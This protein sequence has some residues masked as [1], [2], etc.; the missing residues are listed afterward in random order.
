MTRRL[1]HQA[2]WIGNMETNTDNLFAGGTSNRLLL[3]LRSGL[4]LEVDYALELL[5]QYSHSA[6]AAS[7]PF[8]SLPG[9]P[10]AL[11]DLVKTSL[12]KDNETYRRRLEAA[13]VLR[14]LAFEGSQ[15]C[16]DT[17]RPCTFQIFEILYECLREEGQAE[18]T[19]YLLGLAE[20]FASSFTLLPSL[21][22]NRVTLDSPACQREIYP[23]LAELAQS[24]DRALVIGAYTLLGALALNEQNMPVFASRPQSPAMSVHMLSKTSPP[25]STTRLVQRAILLLHLNDSDLL[26]PIF[27]FMYQHTLIPANGALLLLRKDLRDLFRLFTSRIKQEATEETIEYEILNRTEATDSTSKLR[28]MA[29]RAALLST[30]PNL[31]AQAQTD[32][33]QTS[34]PTDARLD[35]TEVQ[36]ILYLPEPQRVK[37]WMHAVFESSTS[38]EITQVALWKAY[39]KQFDGFDTQMK[40]GQVPAMLSASDVI[41]TSSDAFAEA[42]PRVVEDPNQ[43][44]TKRFIISGIRI[45]YRP[46]PVEAISE[47]FNDAWRCKWRD[48]PN[49]ATCSNAEQLYEHLI[50]SH[51]STIS[52]DAPSTCSYGACRHSVRSLRDLT[53]HLRTHILPSAPSNALGPTSQ[54]HA[55]DA[56]DRNNSSFQ[57]KTMKAQL[58]DGGYAAGIGFVAS[59]VMRNCARAVATST[60]RYRQKNQ[61]T[62]SNDE[63]MQ[64]LSSGGD[65]SEEP[66]SRLR[67]VQKRHEGPSDDDD[68]ERARMAGFLSGTL[69]HQHSDIPSSSATL[70]KEVDLDRRHLEK[71]LIALLDVEKEIIA[72]AA[73]NESLATYLMETLECIEMAK[74]AV[75]AI[76]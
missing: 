66:S 65:V 20:I 18:L 44:Q 8:E 4:P 17:I 7:I 68:P 42:Q 64:G 59:L 9:L 29:L 14:N 31:A 49:S 22:V 41:K 16:L 51:I 62:Q 27:E 72:L 60:I 56:L 37:E 25:D 21:A 73:F 70:V 6:D 33:N 23:L 15:Q 38:G 28:G 24:N 55:A 45:K 5:V 10:F 69:A 35:E 47:A 19:L 71:A 50:S 12:A 36:R 13:L 54:V 11:L 67:Y 34:E 52:N 3:S 46:V 26:L 32:R 57:E 74:R 48:C 58:V 75:E 53:Y 1:I 76:P 39:Q 43:P 63:N 30:Y 61:A 40:S 2:I